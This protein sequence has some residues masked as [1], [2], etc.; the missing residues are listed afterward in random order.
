MVVSIILVLEKWGDLE[1]FQCT[2]KTLFYFIG[3]EY[4][5]SAV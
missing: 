3:I 1:N 5:E 2:A 4:T